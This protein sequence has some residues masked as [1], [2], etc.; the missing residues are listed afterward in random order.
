MEGL[1]NA[2]QARPTIADVQRAV[3]ARKG[4][5]LADMKTPCRKRALAWP[6]QVAMRLCREMT[7]SS[8]PK[9]ARYFGDR[10]HTTVLW[11]C[12]K[13]GRQA[14]CNP[15]LAVSLQRYRDDI[16][17]AADWRFV[18]EQNPCAEWLGAYIRSIDPST[19]DFMPETDREPLPRRRVT[20]FRVAELVD[21]SAWASLGGELEG[22]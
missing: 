15:G 19:L 1:G 16:C 12:R 18:I 6:R 7:N 17:D 10:N 22:V 9:V 14:K 5:T 11:A 2:P 13:I 20:V 8:Y 4:L 21:R 3:C